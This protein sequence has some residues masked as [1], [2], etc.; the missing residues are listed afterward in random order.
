[1]LTNELDLPFGVEEA[2][3]RDPYSKGDADYSVTELIGPARLGALRRRYGDQVTEDVSDRVWSLIGQ[4]G[5]HILERADLRSVP[6]RVF[7]KRSLGGVEY[8]ISGQGD[9]LLL[10]EDGN[11]LDDYKFT[12]VGAALT[13]LDGGKSEFEAQLNIYRLML[14]EAYGYEIGKLRDVLLLRDWHLKQGRA[15]AK[16]NGRYPHKQAVVVPMPLWSLED[17]EKYLMERLAA[18]VEAD[19]CDDATLPECSPAE[20]WQ[21]P[22]KYAVVK[23]GRAMKGMTALTTRS[24][25]EFVAEQ[26]PG[27]TVQVRGG[28]PTRCADGYCLVGRSGLCSQWN[29]E[30]EADPALVQD[31]ESYVDLSALD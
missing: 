19:A 22:E 31:E 5:H 9:T 21:K 12:S 4:I 28:G 17:T 6:D 23:K 30:L 13:A 18:H 3:R 11:R 10:A 27:A 2:V 8:T 1:M 25:A 20:R 15:S 14:H 7:I 29:K 16:K 26:N 24:E